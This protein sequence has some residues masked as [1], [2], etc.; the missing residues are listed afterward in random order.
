MEIQT[1]LLCKS[2]HKTSDGDTYVADHLGLHSFYPL[3]G[4]FPLQFSM[5]YYMLLRRIQRQGDENI[6][7]RFDLVD[8]DGR[9]IGQPKNVSAAGIIPNGHRFMTLTGHIH[10]E[11][12]FPGEYSLDITADEHKLPSVYRYSIDVTKTPEQIGA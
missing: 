3:D 7:L 12:P 5:S 2:V 4:I 10:F 9:N 11:F 8:F 6:T 1:F